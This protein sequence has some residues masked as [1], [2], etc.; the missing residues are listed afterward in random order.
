MDVEKVEKMQKYP[1]EVIE[2][3]QEITTILDEEYG[4]YRDV[5]GDLGGYV[6]LIEKEEDLDKLRE[7]NIDLNEDVFEYVELIS[8]ASEQDYT[9]SLIMLSS[10]YTITLIMPM[11]IIPGNLKNLI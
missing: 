7:L 8:V 2:T 4:E 3:I 10:D 5:D 11:N 1:K 6:L 9:N